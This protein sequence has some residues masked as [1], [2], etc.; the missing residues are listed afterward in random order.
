M[1]NVNTNDLSDIVNQAC[2]IGDLK[3][4][5]TSLKNLKEC[6]CYAPDLP[7][8]VIMRGYISGLLTVACRNNDMPIVK[9]LLTSELTKDIINIDENNG[10]PLEEAIL[11]NNIELLTY[12]ISSP[13][14]VKNA[15]VHIY[16]D[17]IFIKACNLGHLEIVKLLLEYDNINPYSDNKEIHDKKINEK[18]ESGFIETFYSSQAEVLEYFLFDLNLKPIASTHKYL[19]V[20]NEQQV[21]KLFGYFENRDLHEKLNSI[22]PNKTD[23]KKKKL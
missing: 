3:A 9:W 4:L 18:L 15:D 6:V 11:K 12:L 19:E 21:E 17:K 10:E 2:K 23:S 5:K 16:E 14:V 22:L 13:D 1:K 20:F 7:V 8:E